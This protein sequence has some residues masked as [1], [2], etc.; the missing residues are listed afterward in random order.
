[1]T[2]AQATRHPGSGQL[3][4]DSEAEVLA[5][6]DALAAGRTVLTVTHRAAL[7]ALHDRVVTIEDGAVR[8]AA[9]LR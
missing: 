9:A 3:D 8:G 2:V 1:M 7:L 4:P 5:A 6:L